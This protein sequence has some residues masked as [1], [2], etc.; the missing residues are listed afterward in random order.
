LCG[1]AD[2]K[3]P[4][5]RPDHFLMP[6]AIDCKPLFYPAGRCDDFSGP[7]S[8]KRG[9]PV[10]HLKQFPIKKQAI[11]PLKT[12][13]PVITLRNDLLTAGFNPSLP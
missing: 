10:L 8:L 12:H 11:H 2:L 13:Y 9:N 4:N 6:H 5:A 7:L 1:R 3:W